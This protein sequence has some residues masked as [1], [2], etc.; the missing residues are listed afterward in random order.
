[1]NPEQLLIS[2]VIRSGEVGSVIRAGVSKKLFMSYSKEWTWIE[3][4]YARHHKSPEKAAFR[5]AFPDF[6]IITVDDVDALI[7][8]VREDYARSS[9]LNLMDDVASEM[10]G[11]YDP[12]VLLKDTEKA[13]RAITITASAESSVN[14]VDEWEDAFEEAAGRKDRTQTLGMPGISTGFPTLDRVTG[15]IQ[16]GHLWIIG[17]RLGQ[18]KTW[19]L[20]K[21][22]TSAARAGHSV[23][24]E[25]LEQPR[26]QIT[27]RLHTFLSGGQFT[28]SSLSDGTVKLDEYKDWLQQLSET[29][30]GTIH[31][32]DAT[33]GKASV[34]TL[35][36]HVERH[37][38]D[39]LV[40]DYLTLLKSN[41]DDWR[42]LSNLSSDLK[43]LAMQY[44]VGIVCAA[45]LNREF[46]LRSLPG[47]EALA[48]SDAFGQDAD[49][50][51]TMRRHKDCDRV[52]EMR[53]SKYRHGED[54]IVFNARFNPDEGDFTEIS[55]SEVEKMANGL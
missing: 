25:S 40:V 29:C 21:A 46:G 23:H 17:A 11:E 19:W 37:R 14:I 52:M 39:I 49:A 45:Q 38:P 22:A 42:A 27:T 2:A 41:G 53:L 50:V 34:A 5:Q 48:Q 10:G 1:M 15:G 51:I 4:H 8:P 33:R 55:E 12:V 24:V 31:V 18:G 35:A 30:P 44:G 20:V 13:V 54:G 16:G 26:N 32:T 36:S 47:P 7:D 43:S 6:E 3:K 9:L 28:H